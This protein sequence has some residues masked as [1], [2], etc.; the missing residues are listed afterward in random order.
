MSGLPSSPWGG[1]RRSSLTPLIGALKTL[2]VVVMAY[3]AVVAVY[4]LIETA[5]SIPSGEV[6]NDALKAPAF[7]VCMIIAMVVFLVPLF[8]DD[9]D[10]ASRQFSVL[11][12]SFF[13]VY[14][15]L[16]ATHFGQPDAPIELIVRYGI[17]PLRAWIL[18]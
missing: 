6:W 4:A 16:R 11:A 9:S 13:V 14:S 17:D 2:G 10:A 15:I 7:F 3:L 8:R 1:S 18:H 5:T 12:A